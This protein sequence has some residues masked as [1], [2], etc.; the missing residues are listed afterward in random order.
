MANIGIIAENN[1]GIL[2]GKIE[3][4]AVSL[5]IRLDPNENPN[6]RAPRFE[7]KAL[8]SARSWIRVGALFEHH[9]NS[10]GEA[11]LQGTL[12]DPSWKNS[13]SI[14]CFRQDDGSYAVAW[15]R[16]RSRDNVFDSSPRQ[17][18]GNDMSGADDGLGDSTAPGNLNDEIPAFEGPAKGGRG[19]AK[20]EE[21]A[22]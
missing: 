17:S 11:F 7:V 13:L 12:D 10:T 19:K 22:A 20:Q 6:P 15:S 18:E 9:S 3:T 21:V 16:P 14:A 2:F 4:L 8:S 5:T 1:A